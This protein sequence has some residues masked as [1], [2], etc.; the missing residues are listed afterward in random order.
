MNKRSKSAADIL[1]QKAE[2]LLKNK[3][4]KTG[5]LLT[6]PETLKLI[7]ELEVHQI[8]LE[9]QNEELRLAKEQIEI[10]VDKYVELYDFAPS[11]Y[12]TV[13][14]E[15][16][17]IE[18]NLHGSQML[19]NDRAHLKN[20]PLGFFI[21]DLSKPTFNLFLKKI[22]ISK[23]TETCEIILSTE[24][25]LPVYL[26][27]SGIADNNGEKC[28]ITAIDITE[29]RQAEDSLHISLTKYQTLFDLLP[30]GITIS[31]SGGKILETNTIAE[32]LLGISRKEQ[33]SRNIDGEEWQVIRPDGSKMP[34]SEFASVRALAEGSLIDNMELGILK[35]KG[36]V[37]WLNVSATPVP[38]E[39]YGVVVVYNDISSRK[40]FEASR[41]QQLRFTMALKEISEDVFF[42][43]NAQE[44]LISTNRII[45]ET[46]QLDRALIYDV[47]FEK[48]RITGLCEWLNDEHPGIISV[49]GIHPLETISVPFKEIMKTHK[50]LE[51]HSNEVG[52]YFTKDESG[53]ILHEDFKIKSLIWYP[54]AFDEHGYHVF[55]LNQITKYRQWSQ[56]EIDFLESASRKIG[57]AMMK[58]KL[59]AERK[60]AEN[61]LRKL[62]RA[63]EQSPTSIIITDLA[64][65]IVYG[66]PKI[67]ELTGYSKE[68][69]LGKNPRILQSGETSEET[70]KNLWQTITSGNEWRGELYNKKKNG[71]LYWEYAYMAPI[72]DSEGKIINFL[73]VKEDITER[74]KMIALLNEAK[75]KA[76][77]NDKLKSA[78]LANMSH[79]IRTPMNGILGFSELLKEPM[80]SGEEQ[81]KYI[82]IIQKSGVR[83][84]NIINDVVDISKIEA[85]QMGTV[86]SETNV[87]EKID[88]T[89]NFF[90][91]AAEKKGIH[92]SCYKSLPLTQSIIK[93]DGEKLHAI[94]TNLV[95]NAIKFTHEGSIEFGYKRKDLFLEFYIKDTG[96]GVSQ[97]QKEII[98][99]RFIQ[100]G[101]LLTSNFEGTGLGLSI[102]KAYT[103][104]LGG[105]I[106]IESEEGNGSVFYFTIPYVTEKQ[107]Q[108][109]IPGILADEDESN[110][111][112]NLKILIAEDD[113]TSDFLVTTI[114]NNNSNHHHI[115][116]A[117]TGIG[118]IEVC[119]NNPDLDLILMDIRLADMDGLEVTNQIRRFNKEVVIIA[120]TA[121][122]LAGDK[123]KAIEAGCD[124]YISKPI[125][126]YELLALIQK[127][128]NK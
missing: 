17:I 33:E 7:H 74:K 64:G 67:C 113:E 78:F 47:S 27:L 54:F 77:E 11:G 83:L 101:K 58:I 50:Y 79:E 12:F 111:I 37:T 122:A 93:T 49:K 15:G 20:H 18:L 75:A 19:G 108:S 107:M 119:H 94:L 90:K 14:V 32:N 3:S 115:L 31:D 56:A 121:Y 68:E 96:I 42:K 128:C 109:N 124:D 76:E 13:S 1:R 65:N 5:S 62:S 97:A 99:E 55:T 2:A 59:L 39:G 92:L 71:E 70:Y 38:L 118:A 61:E 63:V 123:E 60:H 86:L 16:V 52:E 127:H 100:G 104:M 81:E 82:S 53:K 91:P 22:F 80:I 43:D 112:K 6:E 72:L 73:A 88:Y 89:Y 48:N 29:R 114:L 34:D 26:H 120:Q 28:F 36:K 9:L 40:N 66:N 110:Q 44:I 21:S 25:N 117:E 116:H 41:D 105:K 106:W 87:N 84:L 30:I 51:S 24:N 35:P 8:E 103:E 45:G 126:T 98:F 85:G 69:L 95:N 57:L 10:E 46:L 4:S 125:D 23:T 102:S